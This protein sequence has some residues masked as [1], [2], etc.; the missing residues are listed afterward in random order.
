MRSLALNNSLLTGLV[1]LLAACGQ[2]SKALPTDNLVK[3]NLNGSIASTF[4]VT[5]MLPSAAAAGADVKLSGLG[6]SDAVTILVGGVAVAITARDSDKSVHFT[7]PEGTPGIQTVVVSKGPQSNSLNLLRLANDGAAVLAGS[8]SMACKGETYYGIDGQKLEGTRDCNNLSAA[9]PTDG[10]QIAGRPVDPAQPDP[11]SYLVW[12]GNKWQGVVIKAAAPLTFD[13]VS[14]ALAM[15]SATAT[16]DGYLAAIDYAKFLSKQDAITGSTALVVGGLIASQKKSLEMMPYGTSSGQTSEVHFDALSGGNYVGFKA[17]DAV[18]ASLIWTLPGADGVS[19]YTLVTDG[20][21]HTS[22]AAAGAPA[23]PNVGAVGTYVKVTTDAQ[24]RITAGTSLLTAA[25]IPNLDAGVIGSGTLSVARGGTGVSSTAVFP[26]SGTVVTEAGTETLTNKTLSGGTISSATINGATSISTTGSVSAASITASGTVTGAALLSQ[27]PLRIEGNGTSANRLILNDKGATNALAFKAPDNLGTSTTW[28]LPA[29]DGAVGQFLAT[30]GSGSFAWVSVGAPTGSAGGDLAGTY[31]NPTLAT[32]GVTPGTYAKVAVD[33]K[34]RV[35]GSTALVAG[36]LP[37]HSAA[38][39]SSG[40]L[41]VANGGTG[42]TTITNNGVVIG[43]GTGPLSSV[44]G[45]LNQVMTVNASSQPVFGTINLSSAAAVSGTLLVANGGTGVTTGA[46]NLMFATPSGSSGAPSL[47]ALT[48][49]DLPV[50]SASLITSG[51]LGV[52]SGGTGL[53]TTPTNGQ[54][55]VGNGAGYSLSNIVGGAGLTVSNSSGTITIAASADPSLMLKKDGSTPLTGP[56][57]VGTQDLTSI[58]NMALAASK[59][60]NLGTYGVDPA[61][62]IAADKGKIWFNTATNQMKYWDGST[63]Q[64]LGVSGAGL[65][66]LNGQSGSTQTFAVTAT[67]TAPAINS[68]TNVHTLSIPLA[69]TASVTAGLISNT[70]YAAFTAKQAAGN[71]ITALTGDLTAAGPGSA[72]ATLAPTGVGAGSYTK[73]TVDAK[74]RVSAGT[75]LLPSDI[76][77][78]SASL[79]TTGTLPVSVGGTGATSFTNNGVLLGNTTGNILTTAA[80]AAYQSLTVPSGGG[81]PSFS[82]LNLSQAAA[83]TGTL[84]VANGGTGVTTG[85]ANLMFAT[86]SGSSGAPS[87]RALTATDLPVHSAALITSGTLGVANGGS[88]LATTP[89]NGQILVGNGAGYTLSNIVGGTGLSV[90]NTAGTIT[91]SATADASLMVKKD[92]TTPLTGPWNVGTQDLTSIGNMA[93]AA[94]KTLNLGTYAV[95]P[96]GL[97]TADKGKIWFNSATNQMKYWDG[98]AAQALGI[99]GAGLTSLGGQSGS[100]QTFAVTATGTAPAINSA[101]NVHTLSIPLASTASVTAGLISNT[102]YAAFTAKQ[103]AGNYITALTGDLTAAGPGSAAATLAPTGVGAGSYAKVTVDAKGRVTAGASLA[104]SDIPAHSAAL[105][106]SGTLATANGGTGVNSSATFPTTG[107]VVTEGATETLTNKTLTAPVIGTI[108][109]T[110]TLTLPTSTDTLVGRATTDTLTNK[111]LTSPVITAGTINGASLITG[112]TSINTTGTIASGA[113]STTGGLTIR[114]TGAAS[115]LMTLNNGANTFGLNFKAPDA[116]A[117]SVTWVWPTADGTSGQALS[118]NGSGSFSWVSGLAPSGAAGGDLTG[119]YPSPTLTTT[120]VTAGSYTKVTVDA[121]GRVTTGSTLAA[122]DIPP[123][124]AS[125]IG[126]G[127]LGVANGGTGAATI[128]NNGVVIGAGAG[129]L[130]GVTGSTGQVMIVNASNQPTFGTV[131]L[132]TAAAVTG[133]L[134]VANGGTGVTTGAANLMFATPSG[135]SGAPSL[136]ALT[137]TDLPVHSAA[138]ITS[139]TLGVANGGT[140]LS[141]APANG[142]IPIGN[143]TNFTLATLSSGTG[144]NVVNSAGAIT[145]NATAD[146]STKVTKAGD[147]MT[148]VLNL[149]A[150]G[151]VAGLNQLVLSGG[152]VGIGTTAPSSTF[153]V[154]SGAKSFSADLTANGTDALVQLKSSTTSDWSRFGTNGSALA[155]LTQGGD[156]SGTAPAMFIKN[157]GNVGIGTTTPI[158]KLDISGNVAIGTYGGAA[159]AP[160]NG[161]IVSGNVGIGANFNSNAVNSAL[162]LNGAVT[163]R[164]ATAPTTF[165]GVASLYFNGTKLM[166]QEGVAAPVAVL[167]SNLVAAGAGLAGGTISAANSSGTISLATV[168]LS[169]GTYVGVVT[170]NYGRVVNATTTITS[171]R[172][173]DASSSPAASVVTTYDASGNLTGNNLTSNGLVTATNGLVALPT[174]AVTCPGASTGTIWTDSNGEMWVCLNSQ[175][176]AIKH[177]GHLIFMTSTKYDGSQISTTAQA[178][179]ACANA[180]GTAGLS[181]TF[182]AVYSTSTSNAN[183][184]ITLTKNVYNMHGDL[185]AKNS[186]FWTTSHYSA[187]IYNEYGGSE[188]LYVNQAWTATTATGTYDSAGDCLGST[189]GSKRFGIGNAAS[190]ANNGEWVNSAT[191]TALGTTTVNC[192]VPISLMCIGQ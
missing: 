34:G 88:G 140:G 181:G 49:T 31:P 156:A 119:T 83:V 86:P 9:T 163:L 12:T 166:A 148:G 96:S 115:N 6:L 136:R 178:D 116:L 146:A 100:T 77:P 138:L 10:R 66:S 45:T 20:N 24:G 143:A 54:I 57:N 168:G 185:V 91:I 52:A 173:S 180:A 15:A 81:T 145:I 95:D 40:T 70:D 98:S 188:P 114:G 120:G 186:T 47:R 63:A 37:V 117:A 51:T 174:A 184:R 67:G 153:Q 183:A 4:N 22:W 2:G 58:G 71:Y 155:F 152:N 65:T 187:V 68:A 104:A 124:P 39:I 55:L 141:A 125:I 44:T 46:A 103:A 167:S 62:L 176:L 76:P 149:P 72:A 101:T 94:S 99:S 190:I 108:V 79:I 16:S 164:S 42:A 18:P 191:S 170:D 111:T 144:I 50:H 92:G 134:A 131:N 105:I 135:S 175:K 147:T 30:N 189:S 169:A 48:A 122:S 121:K 128:T 13:P 11:G 109:N 159:A 32:T 139:G 87:L 137:A 14:G 126:S 74:G 142:Q 53:T 21:G 7:V 3:S 38:L 165:A 182:K 158:N 8:L 172:I 59:T 17:P 171:S 84:A 28:T 27:G 123:L 23:L 60:L 19:G 64:A 107:V 69:S 36:D 85:A 75:T 177:S 97:G 41:T 35:T 154:T 179:T 90:A 82:A 130:S 127:V 80:G 93:L 151:L 150:N 25:D 1:V 61:G 29:G 192:N 110:G 161:M 113:I 133:T 106:T 43:A 157:N 56:W 73:V 26:T 102:D 33:A 112:S 132:G 5:Q 78:H 162:D 160:A 89:T 129:A 118:T